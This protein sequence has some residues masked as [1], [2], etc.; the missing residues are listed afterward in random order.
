MNNSYLCHLNYSYEMV[1]NISCTLKWKTS[2]RR[3]GRDERILGDADWPLEEFVP[4]PSDELTLVWRCSGRTELGKGPLHIEAHS[5]VCLP[6]VK[7]HILPLNFCPQSKIWMLQWCY[8]L[9]FCWPLF[10]RWSTVW[11]RRNEPSPQNQP[12]PQP[13]DQPPGWSCWVLLTTITNLKM[14]PDHLVA[15]PQVPLAGPSV[16]EAAS[17]HMDVVKT[18]HLVH[19]WGQYDTKPVLRMPFYSDHLH[20]YL[21][22]FPNNKMKI[23]AWNFAPKCHD[24]SWVY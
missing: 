20:Q 11:A 6:P 13:W 15:Y 2:G 5:C 7:T 23:W 19:L 10:L 17:S 21:D 9:F 22:L 1:Q 4:S 3:R 8:V 24:L 16:T 18:G 12:S 14:L